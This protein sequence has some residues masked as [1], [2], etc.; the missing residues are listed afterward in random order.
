[1]NYKIIEIDE[2]HELWNELVGLAIEI[3]PGNKVWLLAKPKHMISD[4]VTAV[5]INGEIVGFHRFILQ[6]LGKHKNKPL[7]V[8]QGKTLVEA[9]AK[10][11]GTK[12]EW[13]NQGIGRA[14]Q[15]RSMVKAKELGCYQMRAESSYGSDAHFHLKISQGF[16]VQINLGGQSVYFVKVL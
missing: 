12:E 2:Q 3:N 11:Q 15:E 16:G 14:M 4:H 8:F 13:R 6:P 9:E 7:I 5:I 1:M 10:A